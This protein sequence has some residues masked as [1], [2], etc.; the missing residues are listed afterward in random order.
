MLIYLP[1][2][3]FIGV[4]LVA[5]RTS[6]HGPQQYAHRRP[7]AAAI[8]GAVA[9]APAARRPAEVPPVMDARGMEPMTGSLGA[10]LRGE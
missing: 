9:L 8:I 3:V 7:A 4:V 1:G 6:I 2:V 5:W 10:R